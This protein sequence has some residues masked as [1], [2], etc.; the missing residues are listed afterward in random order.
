MAAAL[1][2][3]QVS[4]EARRF[5]E[6]ARRSSDARLRMLRDVEIVDLEIASD[7][8]NPA[9]EAGPVLRADSGEAWQDPQRLHH[10]ALGR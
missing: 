6:E 5:S 2:E 10:P 7:G 8:E 4:E 3:R 1:A 9:L